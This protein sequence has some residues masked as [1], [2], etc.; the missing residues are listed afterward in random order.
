[1]PW[2]CKET[3]AKEKTLQFKRMHF[4]NIDFTSNSLVNKTVDIPS[5]TFRHLRLKIA[6]AA[7]LQEKGI[8]I[9]YFY[10]VKLYRSI[11]GIKL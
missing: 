2:L 6:A 3:L 4:I 10:C 9:W 5:Q 7:Y 8:Y 11:I 1:M